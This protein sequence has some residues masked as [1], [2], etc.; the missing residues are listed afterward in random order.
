M[1][2]VIAIR[3]AR[4]GKHIVP[5]VADTTDIEGVRSTAAAAFAPLSHNGAPPRAVLIG[6]PGGKQ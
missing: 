1:K 6:I 2:L 4:D 5:V 3:D